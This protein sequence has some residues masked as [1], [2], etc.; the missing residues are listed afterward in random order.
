[1]NGYKRSE[2]VVGD[3]RKLEQVEK[4]QESIPAGRFLYGKSLVGCFLLII[5]GF[6]TLFVCFDVKV[7]D[8]TS[9]LMSGILSCWKMGRSV[10]ARK[11]KF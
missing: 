3:M 7:I 1:M 8:L 5:K 11:S 9:S 10:S 2:N 6:M 4:L